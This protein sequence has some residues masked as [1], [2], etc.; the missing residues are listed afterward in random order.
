M[1]KLRVLA[2]MHPDLVPPP[3]AASM[4][5]E[6]RFA[7]K[8]EHDVVSTLQQLGHE[9]R[10][11]GVQDELHPIRDA[12]E[13]FR[14]D[15]AFNLLEEFQGNVL[16]DQNVVSLLELLR[17]PYTGCNPRGL[18]ISREKALSKKLLVYHRIRVPAFHAFPRGLKVRRPRTLGFPLI[19]KSLTEH[20]SLGISKASIV[21][22]D[23]ELAERVRFV[24]RRV[25]TDAIAEQFIEG[26]EVYVGVLGNERLTALPARELVIA[27]EHSDAP[28]IAT[29]KVKHDLEYQERHGIAQKPAMDLPPHVAATLP[30]LSKRIYRILGLSGYARVDYR[31]SPDGLIWCLEANP[32]PEIAQSEE[33]ASAAAQAGI[34][35]PELLQRLLNLGLKGMASDA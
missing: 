22:D 21:R 2:L 3:D 7:F 18:I 35:Y 28:T 29:E 9:V 24:H 34:G 4:S 11:L 32:N 16:F 14:P 10:A 20:S 30:H 8:T 12:V 6:S 1:K 31:V 33:F 13:E 25:K 15:V 23:A 26:R 5:P 19:V 27:S 17:V